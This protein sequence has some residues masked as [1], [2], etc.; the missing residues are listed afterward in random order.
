MRT[1]L[2]V[3]CLLLGFSACR[4]PMYSADQLPNDQILFGTGGGFSGEVNKFI[5]LQ[6]GQIFH[7]NYK[8]YGDKSTQRVVQELEP[9][10]KKVAAE[11]YLR[12]DSLRLDK[13]DFFR[14]GNMYSFMGLQ[15][16]LIDHEVRWGAPSYPVREDVEDL[17]GS[18]MEAIK[19][20]RIIVKPGEEKEETEEGAYY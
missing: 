10:P 20:R 1:I 16:E 6:N 9:M 18:L 14:P 8:P 5:L 11:F 7:E 19:G 13:Y 4:G 3:G 17:H 15:T 2:L 12:M